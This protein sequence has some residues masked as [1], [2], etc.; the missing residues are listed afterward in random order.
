MQ[1]K[2]ILQLPSVRGT[3]V[4]GA[5]GGGADARSG[6]AAGDAARRPPEAGCDALLHAYPGLTSAKRSEAYLRQTLGNETSAC[7]QLA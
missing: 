7:F 1:L 3:G 2:L 6:G 5:G 4:G